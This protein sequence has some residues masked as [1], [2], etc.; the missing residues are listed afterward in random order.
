LFF[1]ISLEELY[2]CS[3]FFEGED[4]CRHRK[5]ALIS[6]SKRGLPEGSS[7]AIVVKTLSPFLAPFVLTFKDDLNCTKDLFFPSQMGGFVTFFVQKVDSFRPRGSDDFSDSV[8][9][10]TCPPLKPRFLFLPLKKHDS[11]F[12]RVSLATIS[13]LFQYSQ[14]K[15]FSLQLLFLLSARRSRIPQK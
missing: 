11:S 12:L 10:C 2:G 8:R 14:G 1:S 3:F 13:P 5:L 4:L 15:F 7:L 9:N 6:R